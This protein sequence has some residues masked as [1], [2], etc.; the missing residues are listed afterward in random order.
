MSAGV[1]G[2]LSF[3]QYEAGLRGP[4]RGVS[5]TTTDETMQGIHSAI[6]QATNTVTVSEPKAEPKGAELS[7]ITPNARVLLSRSAEGR[8]CPRFPVGAAASS[9]GC[10]PRIAVSPRQPPH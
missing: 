5:I 9:V 6:V 2:A 8:G 4:V 7:V 1:A 3:A 10:Q